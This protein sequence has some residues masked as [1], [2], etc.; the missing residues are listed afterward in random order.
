MEP[1][2]GVSVNPSAAHFEEAYRIAEIADKSGLDLVGMQDHST[3][4]QVYAS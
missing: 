3:G 1:L 2:F 4:S